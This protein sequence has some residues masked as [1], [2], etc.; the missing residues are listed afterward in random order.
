[1]L[2]SQGAS[3]EQFLQSADELLDAYPR[4]DVLANNAG[5]LFTSRHATPDGFEQTFALNPLSPFLLTNL[6]L[7]RLTTSHARELASGCSAR[8]RVRA[9]S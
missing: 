4:I 7:E 5:A 3:G 8:S 6:L 2:G 9:T 1:V